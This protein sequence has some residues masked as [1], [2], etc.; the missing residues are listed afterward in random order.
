[1]NIILIGIG[2]SLRGDDGAGPA[3]VRFWEETFHR[4]S[5]SPS[6][7]IQYSETPGLSLLEALTG[8]DAAIFVD[9]IQTGLPPGSIRIY[10]PLPAPEGIT[11]AGKSAHGIGLLETLAVAKRAGQPLPGQLILVGIEAAGFDLGADLDPAVRL[12]IPQAAGTVQ[13]CIVRLTSA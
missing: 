7:H 3:S 13:D 6:I 10:D 2:Q 12:A 1:M 4:T 11:A 8:F 5:P 9:S